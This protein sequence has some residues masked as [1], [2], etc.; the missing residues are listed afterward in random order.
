VTPKP[1][2]RFVYVSYIRTTPKRLWSALTSPEFTR[3]YWLGVTVD[4]D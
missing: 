4:A 2:S 1:A 3:Q